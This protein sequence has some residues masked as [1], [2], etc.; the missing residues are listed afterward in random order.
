MT[1]E[2]EKA[3]EELHAAMQEAKTNVK[4]LKEYQELDTLQR[5]QLQEQ[6]LLLAQERDI[7]IAAV[8]DLAQKIIDRNQLTLFRQ[9]HVGGKTLTN[10]LK[11]FINLLASKDTEDLAD[12]QEKTEQF[13]ERLGHV[14]A[15]IEHPE[16]AT[17]RKLQTVCSSLNKH[18]QYF[19]SSDS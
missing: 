10:V 13:R 4:L 3:Q 11:H 14:G 12:L 1:E 18:L 8:Y 17:Q 5:R 6:A 2:A 9:L 16:K 15:E 7:W 19:H